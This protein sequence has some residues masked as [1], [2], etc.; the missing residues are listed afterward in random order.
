MRYIVGHIIKCTLLYT[1]CINPFPHNKIL[2]QA[3]LKAFADDKLNVTK[4]IISFFDRVKN[5]VG[6]RRNCLYKQFLLFPT[7]FFT[8]SKKEIII[9]VT[10]NLSSANA[11]NLAWY[12]QFLLFLQC[13]QKASFLR[14]V[15]RCHCVRTGYPFH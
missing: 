12:K 4:M 2:D 9:F 11:F 8:L 15:K 1:I 7:M 14:R 13:F 6:K 5:I 10:F 3:K